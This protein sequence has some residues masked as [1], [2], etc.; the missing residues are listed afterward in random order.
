MSRPA[1]P[2]PP[3]EAHAQ[4]AW[5]DSARGLAALTVVG[6]HYVNSY[7]LPCRSAGCSWLL[8]DTPLHLWWDGGAAVSLFFVLSG[9]VLSLRH[10]RHGVAP[11]L[12]GF[13][14]GAYAVGRLCRI[15]LP[16]LAALAV[17]AP[18]YWHWQAALPSL[19]ATLPRMND[20]LPHV[21]GRPA[22]WPELARDSF[23]LG[24]RMDMVYLPQAWTLSVELALSL[25]VPAGVL[26]A[27]RST[28]W[29]AC[30]SL[31]AI[32][33][34]GVSPFLF[35]FML[36][37]AVAKHH[38]RLG[39]WLR[40]NPLARRVGWA[41]GFFLY[42]LGETLGDE[43]GYERTGWPTGL[44]AALLLLLAFGS[45]R[46]QR[47]L[48]L[49]GLRQLGKLS[50]SLYLLHFTVLASATPPLLALLDAPPSGLAWAWCAGLAANLALCLAAAALCHRFVEAPSLA[51]GKRL[52]R[53]LTA[54]AEQPRPSQ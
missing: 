21:W 33:P 27:A 22:G 29:L 23:L 10:F 5:L 39:R 26:L 18:L 7:D 46:A 12:A 3:G 2:L 40:L 19:P 36:G 49:P 31:F 24:M 35:H 30:L 15:W 52:G 32:W 11:D 1:A 44:G 9:L 38:A 42:T 48:S 14:L 41:L 17:S 45:E 43:I 28:A 4:V 54:F 20:W 13:S 16:Y 25:L 51:L 53:R 47:L 34:L 6:S 8:S 37:I 50:Y